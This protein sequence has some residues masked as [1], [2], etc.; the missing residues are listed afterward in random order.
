LSTVKI[1]SREL[2]SAISKPSR[3]VTA[4]PV[5]K[6]LVAV[7][8]SNLYESILLDLME[9]SA[10][11]Q[12]S[13]QKPKKISLTRR[14]LR[15]ILNSTVKKK[16]VTEAITVR[17]NRRD[18]YPL[19]TTLTYT[20]VASLEQIYGASD[21]D[22][23]GQYAYK[24]WLGDEYFRSYTGDEAKHAILRKVES[25]FMQNPNAIEDVETNLQ[26]TVAQ[27]GS[28]IS[29]AKPIYDKFNK[30]W[31]YM[32]N[33]QISPI[34]RMLAVKGFRGVLERGATA[35]ADFAKILVDI[36]LQDVRTEGGRGNPDVIGDGLKFEVGSGPKK[37]LWLGSIENK[38][39]SPN[40]AI[41]R[42]LL[43][44]FIPD[45]KSPGQKLESSQ[46]AQ[47]WRSCGS[48]FLVK[49]TGS[50]FQIFRITTKPT[51][52]G[53][54]YINLLEDIHCLPTGL[55]TRDG[56]WIIKYDSIDW[57]KATPFPF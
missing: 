5:E 48:D 3:L 45:P 15:E 24:A 42:K 8:E 17:H 52:L 12:K 18:D 29:S 2:E 35:E 49:G 38:G 25:F 20:P 28:I 54:I 36:G 55:S 7:E 22:P 43:D 40:V 32:Y 30:V 51:R 56:G 50:R 10:K 47:I 1:K 16:R 9:A 31:G 57:S 27:R 19:E 46:V 44:Q 23:G 14:Q 37:H 6:T 21:S 4:K 34:R 33:G 39:F 53:S 13:Q 26:N 41:R 11:K